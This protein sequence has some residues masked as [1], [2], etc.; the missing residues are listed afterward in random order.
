MTVENGRVTRIQGDRDHPLS[1]GFTCPKGRHWGDM[2]HDPQR[3]VNSQRRA[4]DGD[5]TPV[6]VT[7]A[8]E[9]IA[10]RLTAIID[11]H[12]P[13]SVA[14]FIGTQAYTATLTF[15][16]AN[17]WQRALGTHKNFS[18]NT[19]DQ[20]AKFVAA[21]RLGSW[22]GGRQRFEDSDV[23][24]LAG[25]NP[26]VS[27]QGGEVSGIPVHG[28]PR[29]LRAAQD[30][31]MTFIVVDPR[32][33]ETAARADIHLQLVPGTDAML[34]AGLIREILTNGWHDREF[35]DEYADHLADLGRA[36]EAATPERVAAATGLD[37]DE[38]RSAAAAFGCAER[39]MATS[40]TGA[41]MGPQ[42]N[43]AEHLLE[44]LNVICGRFPR[45][46]DRAAGGRL[47]GD[48]KPGGAAV[49]EPSRPWE[50]GFRSRVGSHGMLYGNQLP[51][52]LLP[53]EILSPGPDR[54]R[55]L[56]VCG[57]NPAACIPDQERTVD[58]LR[59]LD[60]LVTVDPYPS[61]TAR[62]ADYVIAP[63]L[64]LERADHTRPNE[65]WFSDDFGQWTDPV[66]PR[67]EGVIEDW[68]FWLR[69]GQAMR[70]TLRIGSREYTPD[71]PVPSAE[72]VLISFGHRSRIP[73]DEIRSHPHGIVWDDPEPATVQPSEAGGLF[74]LLPADV[75]DEL[76]AMFAAADRPVERG[77][78]LTVRRIKET[79]NTLGRRIPSL[80]AGANPL[81]VH[82]DDA[83]ALGV[84][85]GDA[86]TVTSDHGQVRAR[87]RIDRA[88]RPG[89]VSITHCYGDLPGADD[90]PDSV[91]ANPARLLSHTVGVQPISAMPQMTA[92]RVDV[93]P[94]A[95]ADSA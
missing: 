4:P 45:A 92:V 6:P 42:A 87:V 72:D 70:Y 49:R 65:S 57:G 85:E 26:L 44:A 13:D 25:S 7:T 54:V 3:F 5:L 83:A 43:L 27:M 8:I 80:D 94:I 15:P 59:S 56:V 21:E 67:P 37:A 66:L 14:F 95:A 81:H 89:T 79:M 9:E 68:E 46:G 30:N 75:A 82:P 29:R 31:G 23:W 50:R 76:A 86:V 41:N 55:A 47:I 73:L 60:L 91:G 2:H 52:G 51:T 20:S 24:L 36:V 1:S 62:L 78:F 22:R 11:E 17:A 53:D 61:E 69:L 58:A 10:G 28:G 90:D 88:H 64:G 32:R 16:F 63:T 19:I 84:A 34:Y 33:S 93:A 48:A 18:T 71:T 40:G 38:L 35:C 12:G 77:F 39:G 74:R